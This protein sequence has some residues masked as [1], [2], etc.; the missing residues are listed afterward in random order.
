MSNKYWNIGSSKSSSKDTNNSL[1]LAKNEFIK[2]GDKMLAKLTK[3][4]NYENRTGNLVSSYAYGIFYG[5]EQ[6]YSN[7]VTN[8]ATRPKVSRG[9]SY[10]ANKEI[11][12]GLSELLAAANTDKL[13]F[14]VFSAMFYANI[15]ETSIR[16]K[17]QYNVIKN[18]I[19]EDVTTMANKYKGD[20]N[21]Y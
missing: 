17:R 15:L 10:N 11:D 3:S 16:T 14:V 6:L 1:E 7:R 4:K 5:G 18:I 13:T 12:K 2:Y 8:I 21:E 20:L 9:K 19:R